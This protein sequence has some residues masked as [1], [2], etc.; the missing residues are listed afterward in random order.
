VN[1]NTK[2]LLNAEVYLPILPNFA[3]EYNKIFF[4]SFHMIFHFYDHK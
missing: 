1:S 4:V 2:V 3:V